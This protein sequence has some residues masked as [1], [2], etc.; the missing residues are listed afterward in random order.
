VKRTLFQSN[1]QFDLIV[2]GGGIHG[3]FVAWDAAL[4]GL[5]VALLEQRDFGGAT[6]ANSLKTIHGGLRYLQ[7]GN[8]QLVKAMIRERAHWMRMAPHLVVT[9]PFVIPT[10]N[11]LK[12][13][14]MTLRTALKVNDLLTT[15]QNRNLKNPLPPGRILSANE[16]AKIRDWVEPGATGGALWHDAQ[17]FDTERLLISVI[18]SAAEAG[19]EVA[20][21]IKVKELLHDSTTICGVVAEDRLTGVTS[22]LKG[23]VVVNCSGAWADSLLAQTHN[24]DFLPTFPISVAINIVTRRL[25]NDFA[26]GFTSKLISR[27]VGARLKENSRLLFVVPWQNH[28]L[29]GTW[30]LPF[31]GAPGNYSLSPSL[32]RDFVDEVNR[33]DPSA[34]LKLRDICHV[35]IGYLPTS[36]QIQDG[37]QIRLQRNSQIHDHSQSDRIENLITV[38]GVKYTMARRAAEDALNLVNKKLGHTVSCSTAQQKIT[39]GKMENFEKYMEVALARRPEQISVESMEHLVRSYGTNSCQLLAYGKEELS[40]INPLGPTSPVL[41]AEVIHAI[42]NEMA[43]TLS[44]VVRRRLPLGATGVPAPLNLNACAQLMAVELGWDQKRIECEI[45]R[46]RSEYPMS[47]IID[48]LN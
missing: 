14:K 34:R 24:I 7:D 30:H 44:D 41:N 37:R 35:H 8:L 28:S 25:H 5:S 12:H 36:T 6:S 46:V 2:I 3:A 19:A 1:Q 26:L 18:L 32:L 43:C 16:L 22:I 11:R 20:N 39:G 23:R 45:S 21:Y 15:P 33:A 17:I 42:R 48:S 47:I 10:Y 29:I 9:Q 38:T 4:R 13:H 31:E 40:W 27:S